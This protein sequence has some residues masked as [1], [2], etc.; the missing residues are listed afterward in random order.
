M[1]VIGFAIS[2]FHG[3]LNKI[4]W[5][6][7]VKVRLLDKE[8]KITGKIVKT[9]DECGKVSF[10]VLGSG[11]FTSGHKWHYAALCPKGDHGQRYW[12]GTSRR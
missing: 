5:Y 11:Y 8:T 3:I 1:N 12:G 10:K 2:L 7:F 4:I 6:D 9:K